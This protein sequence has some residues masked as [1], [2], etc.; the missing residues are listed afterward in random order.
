MEWEQLLIDPN[1][2]GPRHVYRLKVPGGWLVFC[3]Q[4]N[5]GG[6]AFY[7]DEDYS[8]ERAELKLPYQ[9]LP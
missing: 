8:W 6:L 3:S 9:K 1:S 4:G 7:P 5:G 2:P